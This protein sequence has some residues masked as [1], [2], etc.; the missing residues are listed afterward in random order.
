[1]QE[2]VYSY[3]VTGHGVPAPLFKGLSLSPAF[4]RVFI[5]SLISD[6]DISNMLGSV[7]G[8]IPAPGTC[9]SRFCGSLPAGGGV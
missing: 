9:C 7:L 2:T 4:D 8:V 1:M 3:H 5:R 6:I